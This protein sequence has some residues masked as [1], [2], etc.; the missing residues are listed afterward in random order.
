MDGVLRQFV[1][2]RDGGCVARFVGNIYERNRY[3]MMF[4][5]PAPGRCRNQFG[6]DIDT[7]S[8]MMLE[9]DHVKTALRMA[10]RAPD[11]PWHL[12]TICPWHHHESNWVTITEV[13]DAARIYIAASNL[14]VLRNGF[15]VWPE[16][17]DMKPP[18]LES[19]EL[20]GSA[21]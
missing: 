13:K 3:P 16:G 2:L 9:V 12:W 20:M 7:R 14:F 8:L 21:P 17:Y 18:T 10:R 11:D 1:L 6:S 5:L 4:D 15:P 19:G